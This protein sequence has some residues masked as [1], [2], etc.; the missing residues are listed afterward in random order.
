MSKNFAICRGIIYT[1]FAFHCMG[2]FF[3]QKCEILE[4]L[5]H[6]PGENSILRIHRALCFVSPAFIVSHRC[7]SCTVTVIFLFILQ[8][9]INLS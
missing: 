6:F 2:V 4:V 1:G 5:V 9:A 3:S 8:A 7:S